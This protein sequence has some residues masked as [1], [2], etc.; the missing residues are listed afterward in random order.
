MEIGDCMLWCWVNSSVSLCAASTG[1]QRACGPGLDRE[2]L[3]LRLKGRGGEGLPQ[4][5]IG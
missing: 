2:E 3:P 1:I 4:R 5:A